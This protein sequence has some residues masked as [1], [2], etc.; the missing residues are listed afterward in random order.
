MLLDQNSFKYALLV[1]KVCMMVDLHTQQ[2]QSMEDWINS[3]P[4]KQ[5]P[6]KVISPQAWEMNGTDSI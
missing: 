4:I 1:E 6:L 3:L 2:L 5:S